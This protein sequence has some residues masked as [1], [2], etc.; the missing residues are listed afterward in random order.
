[1]WLSG[2]LCHFFV[3][4]ICEVT[5]TASAQLHWNSDSQNS[6]PCIIP[7]SCGPPGRAGVTCGGWKAAAIS[8]YSG[9]VDAR[10][11]TLLQRWHIV[12]NRQYPP[13]VLLICW[14]H[15]SKWTSASPQ[16]PW[17][18]PGLLLNWI[19]DRC[20]QLLRQNKVLAL[21]AHVWSPPGVPLTLRPAPWVWLQDE[22]HQPH[23]QVTSRTHIEA[24]Q[25]QETCVGAS[26]PRRYK[27]VHPSPTSRLS[28]PVLRPAHFRASLHCRKT[29]L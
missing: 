11:Q 20:A 9:R 17:Q 5:H 19:P 22:G 13:P 23:T 28:F 6:F 12:T 21:P 4:H 26:S 7:G 29:G 3:F 18:P 14:L 2:F 15:L 25:W 24:W 27:F 8:L 10:H 1:M 16:Q